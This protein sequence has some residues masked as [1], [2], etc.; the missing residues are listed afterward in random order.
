M[1]GIVAPA[2]EHRA[3]QHAAWHGQKKAPDWL[4]L[5]LWHVV[6]PLFLL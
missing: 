4:V 6:V 1:W 3:M 2:Q 5:F